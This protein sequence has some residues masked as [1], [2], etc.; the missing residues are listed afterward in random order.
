MADDQNVHT[1]IALLGQGLTNLH[2]IVSDIGNKLDQVLQIQLTVQRQQDRIDNLSAEMRRSQEVNDQ[3]IGGFRKDLE[4]CFKV[5]HEGRDISSR[6]LNRFLGGV[7]VGGVLL[8]ALQW[9]VLREMGEY[10]AAAM[11]VRELDLRLQRVESQPQE[12]AK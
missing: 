6:W 3:A 10:K 7:V 4:N 9:F 12:K 11:A 1:E 8:G 2:H 5:A